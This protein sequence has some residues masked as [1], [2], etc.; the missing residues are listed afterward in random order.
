MAL[1]WLGK[2]ATRFSQEQMS[3]FDHAVARFV[4]HCCLS[5]VNSDAGRPKVLKVEGERH[6]WFGIDV[7]GAE[8]GGN[9]ADCA[10]RILTVDG[11]GRFE[12]LGRSGPNPPADVTLTLVAGTAMSK[13]IQTIEWRH[14]VCDEGGRFSL[15]IDPTP[16]AGR[17]NHFR[18]RADA[19]DLFVR[20]CL[21]D[22]KTQRANRLA[23]RRPAFRR[24]AISQRSPWQKCANCSTSTCG[25]ASS[26]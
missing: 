7:P 21:T 22:W 24:T 15:T 3:S 8:R 25:A 18:S 4:F 14:I 12:V 1:H 6:H 16:A 19:T 23:I 11:T 20:D 17:P 9:N 2:V 26:G 13:T 10:Y 5:A